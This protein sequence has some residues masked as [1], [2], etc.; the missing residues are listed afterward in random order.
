MLFYAQNGFA[1]AN[2]AWWWFVPPGLLIAL[3]GMGLSLVNFSI[4]EVINPRLANVR[5]QRRRDRRA[6]RAARSGG[7]ARVATAGHDTKGVAR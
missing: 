4:D 5:A 1:L 2:G 6:K 3:L 7:P